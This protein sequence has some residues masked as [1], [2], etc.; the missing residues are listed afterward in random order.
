MAVF[1]QLWK[2]SWLAA[3]QKSFYTTIEPTDVQSHVVAF[4]LSSDV[5]LTIAV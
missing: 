4:P 1:T 3:N 2:D 5:S